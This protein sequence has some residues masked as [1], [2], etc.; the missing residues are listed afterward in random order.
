MKELLLEKRGWLLQ[1]S[2]NSCSLNVALEIE[3]LSCNALEISSVRYD[4]MYIVKTVVLG[5]YDL[6]RSC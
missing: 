2:I 4:L 3:N 5:L 6:M 1:K